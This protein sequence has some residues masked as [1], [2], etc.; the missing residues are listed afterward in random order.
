MNETANNRRQWTP[1]SRPVCI[2]R[3]WRGAAAPDRW[4][5][6]T[7]RVFCVT[8]LLTF[9]LT[10]CLHSGNRSRSH[11]PVFNMC[12]FDVVRATAEPLDSGTS[13]HFKA[14]LELLLKP[15]G[16]A[17]LQGFMRSCEGEPFEIRVNNEVLLQGVGSSS[18]PD[19]RN[20]TWYTETLSKAERL[21][22]SLNSK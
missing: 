22:A 2:L 4:P 15:E 21:A 3:P 10:G 16:L 9:L 6:A 20:I 13:P 14:Q 19:G 18:I 1:R 8:V 11:E 12:S 7:M 5:A 17:R